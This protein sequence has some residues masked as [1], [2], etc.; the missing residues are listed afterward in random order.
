MTIAVLVQLP[1]MDDSDAKQ[2]SDTDSSNPKTEKKE[3]LQVSE[4]VGAYEA[5]NRWGEMLE[6][7]YYRGKT[8]AVKR[9]GKVMAVMVSQGEYEAGRRVKEKAKKEFFEA[10]EQIQKQMPQMTDEEVETL[11]SEAVAWARSEGKK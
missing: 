11:V 9:R 1:Y 2:T 5:R 6:E 4:T 7:V 3:G 8:F 10:Y